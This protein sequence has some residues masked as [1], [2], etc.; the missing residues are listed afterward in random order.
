MSPT[1]KQQ[2]AAKVRVETDALGQIKIPAERLWGA[3]TQRSLTHFSIGEDH[4]PKAIFHAYGYVKK[5]AA[6]VN[7]MEGKLAADKASLIIKAAEEVIA[8]KLDRE[9]PLV[10]WQTG[11]GV[12]SDTNINEVI[13]N[14]A[15]QLSG[16][17]LGSKDPIHPDDV[18]MSQSSENTFSIAM[19]IATALELSHHLIPSAVALA[20]AIQRKTQ[21]SDLIAHHTWQS[22][23][24]QIRDAVQLVRHSLK[25]LHKLP[26]S[27]PAISAK[28]TDEI[29]QLT[30]QA[31]VSTHHKCLPWVS[32]DAMVASS[33]ALRSLAVALMK[34]VNG[35]R[36]SRHSHFSTEGLT[37]SVISHDD[38]TSQLESL[39]MICIQVIANDNAV[40]MASSHGHFEMSAM[41]PIVVKNVLHSSTILGDGC[42]K[43]RIH[44]VEA[45]PTL[46]H[47][48][49]QKIHDSLMLVSVLTPIIGYDKAAV[50]AQKALNEP[51]APAVV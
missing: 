25:G 26:N 12:Q 9:F 14:R 40:A 28:V 3:Q 18:N 16:G 42:E 1:K 7:Q 21:D 34:I 37:T 20:D 39:V 43:F 35:I 32:L 2:A 46:E 10:V 33:A 11:S 4:M 5:A 22:Y 47:Q 19:H 15:I 44:Y 13:A 36:W 17:K 29:A 45:R 6:I 38:K 49:N 24:G 8:G 30:G 27:I 41:R 31:F 48:R 51:A 23:A 50:I